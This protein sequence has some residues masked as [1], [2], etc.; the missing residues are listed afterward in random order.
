MNRSF[1]AGDFSPLKSFCTLK[2]A[3][4]YPCA[5][6]WCPSAELIKLLPQPVAPVIKTDPPFCNIITCCKGGYQSLIKSLLKHRNSILRWM[7]GSGTCR[8]SQPVETPVVAV[9][10]LCLQQHFQTFGKDISPRR[11]V[12]HKAFQL[13]FTPC[14]RSCVNWFSMFVFILLKFKW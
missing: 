8:F 3:T 12:S 4:L 11:F 13:V 10:Q 7:P 9:L 2:Y 1:Q 5:H 14:K 6:A